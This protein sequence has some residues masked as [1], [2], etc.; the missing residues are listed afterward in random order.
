MNTIIFQDDIKAIQNYFI[1]M[2]NIFGKKYKDN[3]NNK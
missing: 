3:S 2:K 1:F